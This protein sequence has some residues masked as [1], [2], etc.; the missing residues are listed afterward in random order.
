MNVAEDAAGES[1]GFKELS[2]DKSDRGDR[3]IGLSDVLFSSCGRRLEI[4]R[5][6][7]PV[8]SFE[9]VLPVIIIHIIFSGG[10]GSP[11]SAQGF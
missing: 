7:L 2:K 3:S 9:V 8:K 10:S 4:F 11:G 6:V 5:G 1:T